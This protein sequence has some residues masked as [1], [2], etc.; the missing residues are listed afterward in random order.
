M[1]ILLIEKKTARQYQHVDEDRQDEEGQD[2]DAE[3]GAE[4][5]EEDP[6]I[7][8]ETENRFV[9][10]EGRSKAVQGFPLLYCLKDPR[11]ITALLLGFH[12]SYPSRHL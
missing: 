9:V 11:L 4:A 10:P 7:K 3:D 8:K 1:R 2:H 6:L 12:T 5:G